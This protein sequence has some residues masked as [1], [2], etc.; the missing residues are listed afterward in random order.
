MGVPKFYRWLSER[1]PCINENVNQNNIPEFDNFY[2]DM[3]GV[4]HIC[5]HPSDDIHFR[6]TESQIFENISVYVEFLFNLIQ[7]RKVFFLS[8]DGVAPRSKMNQQRSRR[9]KTAKEAMEKEENAKR[10]GETLPDDPRFDSNCITPGTEFMHKLHD[11]MVQFLRQKVQHNQSWRDCE[12]IYSGYDVPGEGEHKIMDYI[13]YCRT[14]NTFDKNVRH[15]LYGLDADLINLGLS[16]HE[17]YFSLLRE[18]V[19]FTKNQKRHCDPFK[20]NFQ[21]L[22]LSILRGYLDKE[23]EELKSKLKFEYNLE[24]IIDDWILMNFLIGNDFLPH[25]PKFHVDKGSIQILYDTYKMV[26]PFL[27]GY[28]NQGGTIHLERFRKYLH[29]LGDHDMELFNGANV[30]LKYFNQ[31]YNNITFGGDIDQLDEPFEF[32]NDEP[33]DDDDNDGLSDDKS[34][35][36]DD[37]TSEEDIQEEFTIHKNNYYRSKLHF[38]NVDESVLKIVNEYIKGVQ[39]VLFYYFNGCVSWNWYY[40]YYYA[41]YVSDLSKFNIVDF[42]F[43]Q[44][45]PFEPLMQLLAVIPQASKEIL[46]KAFQQLTHNHD[47]PLI[48]YFPKEVITDLNEKIHDYEAI[49]LIPFMDETILMSAFRKHENELTIDEIHRNRFGVT[50]SLL[51]EDFPTNPNRSSQ[52]ANVREIK[53]PVDH[54]IL[55]PELIYKGVRLNINLDEIIGFPT[56]N[57]IQYKVK[58]DNA[59]LKVF[60]FPS[61]NPSMLL[62]IENVN[63]SQPQLMQLA[64]TQIGKMVYINWPL[65]SEAK[66]IELIDSENRYILNG[67]NQITIEALNSHEF[68]YAKQIS[69]CHC[70]MMRNKKGI[71]LDHVDIIAKVAPLQSQKYIVTGGKVMLHKEWSKI[72]SYV[73]LEL[74]IYD[75]KPIAKIPIYRSLNQVFVKGKAFFLIDQPYYGYQADVIEYVKRKNMVRARV[76]LTSEPDFMDIR[77]RYNFIIDENYIAE[78]VL[79]SKIRHSLN[80]N[81]FSVRRLL[82][83]VIIVYKDNKNKGKERRMN[84]G[85]KLKYKSNMEMNIKPYCIPGYS[86]VDGNALYYNWKVIHILEEYYQNFSC[87][88]D[89]LASQQKPTYE[90]DDLFCGNHQLDNSEKV[91]QLS[92]IRNWI[93]ALELTKIGHFKSDAK[94]LD[95]CIVKVI[96]ETIESHSVLM[97]EE[98]VIEELFPPGNFYISEFVLKG[99]SLPDPKVK[100]FLMDRVVN[101]KRCIPVPYGA[102]GTIIGIYGKDDELKS[103]QNDFVHNEQLPTANRGNDN[104]NTGKDYL[105]KLL[106]S[107]IEVMFDEP[108]DGGLRTRSSKS[109]IFKMQASWLINV[110]YG[111]LNSKKSNIFRNVYQPIQGTSTKQVLPKTSTPNNKW[112]HRP[113]PP[114]IPS[115]KQNCEQETFNKKVD[116]FNHSE[117]SPFKILTKTSVQSNQN[118]SSSLSV[119][120]KSF[121]PSATTSTT[122]D[123]LVDHQ[124]TIEL[125]KGMGISNIRT[126]K[127]KNQ[128]ST[129]LQQIKPP[130]DLPNVPSILPPSNW[131]KSNNTKRKAKAFV[132]C[133]SKPL[134]Q[135]PIMKLQP[136]QIGMNNGLPIVNNN[137]FSDDGKKSTTVQRTPYNN[138]NNNNNN[139]SDR[140]NYQ[141]QYNPKTYYNAGS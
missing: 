3:N 116:K 137:L 104:D 125:L 13:R 82:G 34:D 91:K 130:I 128:N 26:L 138:N 48:D 75:R 46:P 117:N 122:T 37:I 87:V 113:P 45:K 66:L 120:A 64:Q 84:V 41:P 50:Y 62:T 83:S 131:I 95:N 134:N 86:I 102:K 2:I 107:V 135:N 12:I 69:N 1:Y 11:H 76:H 36:S 96:E 103:Q 20:T 9:Y 51:H 105:E 119:N 94:Y 54:F 132:N 35:S 21:L 73:P 124:S 114:M 25:V 115:I 121:V 44:S 6:L 19:V 100:L 63:Y 98:F 8:V 67:K 42:K 60:R 38:D 23:F 88:F 40:P 97:T 106:N 27:D 141:R 136:V 57:G 123:T 47:S 15:C 90:I 39:W 28:L 49:I 127:K 31:D 18:E 61:Q 99:S 33:I 109:N 4:F 58:L 79:V 30:D 56:L 65:L 71:V 92:S 112:P 68:A 129:S 133:E 80:L 32:N 77:E 101:I 85:L 89:M 78:P 81:D 52:F 70:S 22:H 16:C 17:P 93:D 14:K 59:R 139:S 126:S 108:F 43:Q 140:Q 5:S 29:K 53:Y 24:N 10:L 118:G 55:P 74:V 72:E 110:T 7:P 111:T